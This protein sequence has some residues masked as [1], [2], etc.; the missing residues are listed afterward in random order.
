MPRLFTRMSTSGQR[1]TTSPAA[2]GLAV[3]RAGER[4]EEGDEIVDLALG[5]GEWLHVLV[6][7]GV[8]QPVALVV[9]VDHVPERRLRAVV[10]VRCRH[11]HVAQARRLERGGVRLF[12]R[13]EEAA[14]HRELRPDRRA[15]DRLE[16]AGRELPLGRAPGAGDIV[17]KDADADVVIVEVG[18]VSRVALAL[19]WRMALVAARLGIEALPA[20]LRRVV[21]GIRLAGGEAIERGVERN[22]AA[23]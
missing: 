17:G 7:P 20:A 19:A 8:L 1:R 9:M 6:E 18:E 2:A 5:E 13:D 22:E 14:E 23:L 3:L 16:R 21:D 10:E 12:A 15:V 11:Q 4:G